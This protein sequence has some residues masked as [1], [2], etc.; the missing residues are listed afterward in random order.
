MPDETKIKSDKKKNL[1]YIYMESME[2]TYASREVGGEQPE[3]NYIPNL[4]RIADENISFSD[5]EGLG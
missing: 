3:N 2:T 5:E 4:T 1:I